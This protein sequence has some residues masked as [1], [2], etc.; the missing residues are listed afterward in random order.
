M[1]PAVDHARDR[2]RAD[3]TYNRID[4]DVLINYCSMRRNGRVVEPIS[5]F[6]IGTKNL[7]SRIRFEDG[8][9]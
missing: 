2:Q 1:R 4:W 5:E 6:S 8:V 3:E 9:Q 7:V